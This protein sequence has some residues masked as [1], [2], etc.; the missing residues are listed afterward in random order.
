MA[1]RNRT[2]RA[3]RTQVAIA[4]NQMMSLRNSGQLRPVWWRGVNSR[5]WGWNAHLAERTRNRRHSHRGM[6]VRQSAIRVDVEILVVPSGYN[7]ES[8]ALRLQSHRLQFRVVAVQQELFIP[9]ET[10][11]RTKAE[12]QRHDGEVAGILSDLR[13]LGG[14]ARPFALPLRRRIGRA[15]IE[16]RAFNHDDL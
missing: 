2:H 9:G 5:R 8:V 14:R 16:S 6:H 15:W 7:F 1:A 3:A 4:R 13:K 10:C 11:V 12:A